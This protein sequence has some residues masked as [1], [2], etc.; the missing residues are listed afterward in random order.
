M[1]NVKVCILSV[2]E[3]FFD[4]FYRSIDSDQI[5]FHKSDSHEAFLDDQKSAQFDILIL[6]F[7]NED[8]DIPFLLEAKKRFPRLRI[9]YAIDREDIRLAIQLMKSGADDIIELPLNRYALNRKLETFLATNLDIN[10]KNFKPNLTKIEKRI[11]ANIVKGYSNKEIAEIM[12]RGIRTIEDHKAKI[13]KKLGVESSVELFY[14]A[15]QLD[16]EE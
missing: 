6:E 12:D 16:L 9:W 13:K 15:S 14:K 10:D 8:K 4:I 3:G 11:L 7:A 2:A 5:R 1:N